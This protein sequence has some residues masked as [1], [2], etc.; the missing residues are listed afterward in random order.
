MW[1]LR[2]TRNMRHKHVGSSNSRKSE[3]AAVE[4]GTLCQ[5]GFS[6]ET[7]RQWGERRERGGEEKGG[8][9]ER[10]RERREGREGERDHKKSAHR[11]PEADKHRLAGGQLKG[12][13][14]PITPGGSGFLCWSDLR[15]IGVHPHWVGVR[16]GGAS[17]S[18]SL[19]VLILTPSASSQTHPGS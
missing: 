17:A 1:E 16:M 12:H 2:I 18:L 11:V 3:E 10:E 6:R 15:L 5:A 9:I 14:Q 4:R 8:G 7:S 19:P 13:Q